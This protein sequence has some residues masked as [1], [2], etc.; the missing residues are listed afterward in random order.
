LDG[1]QSP[2]MREVLLPRE[3]EKRTKIIEQFATCFTM[4]GLSWSRAGLRKGKGD[5]K[6]CSGL[7]KGRNK[8]AHESFLYLSV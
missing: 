2:A 1:G 4:L 6:E 5:S 8:P 7:R 3:V